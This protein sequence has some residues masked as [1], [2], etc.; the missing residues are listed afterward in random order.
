L[1]VGASRIASKSESSRRLPFASHGAGDVVCFPRGKEGAHPIIN[2]TDSTIRVLMLSSM[3]G[4]EIIEYL[5]TGALDREPPCAAPVGSTSGVYG[6]GHCVVLDLL[7]LNKVVVEVT[8]KPVP[9]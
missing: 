1:N 8:S 5:D 2:R 3:V 6:D 9:T 7:Q 4:P